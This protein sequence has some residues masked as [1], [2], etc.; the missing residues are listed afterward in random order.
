VAE[1][2]RERARLRGR[3]WLGTFLHQPL[4]VGSTERVPAAVLAPL[5][6]SQLQALPTLPAEQSRIRGV[7]LLWARRVA[8]PQEALLSALALC[9]LQQLNIID[10]A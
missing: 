3:G 9:S 4:A 6:D 10:G 2:A 5:L 1:L 7:G 8:Q